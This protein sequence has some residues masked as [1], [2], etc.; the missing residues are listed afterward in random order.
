MAK[1]AHPDVLGK[2]RH[3]WHSVQDHHSD[4]HGGRAKA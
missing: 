4:Q 2:W 1:Y 3:L